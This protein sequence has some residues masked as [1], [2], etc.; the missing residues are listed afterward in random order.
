MDTQKQKDHD[1]EA[2]SELYIESGW[3][4]GASEKII[5]H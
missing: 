1:F 5:I 2:K 4:Y 3:W